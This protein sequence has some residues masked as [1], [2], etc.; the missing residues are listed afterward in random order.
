MWKACV[1]YGEDHHTNQDTSPELSSKLQQKPNMIWN[2]A[3]FSKITQ[4]SESF[5]ASM[6]GEQS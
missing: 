3:F 6:K 4:L 5:I 1:K 2:G